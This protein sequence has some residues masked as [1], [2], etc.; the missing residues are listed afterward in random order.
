MND[1]VLAVFFALNNEGDGDVDVG[2]RAWGKVLVWDTLVHSTP[3]ICRHALIQNG[4]LMPHTLVP[5][6]S[7]PA[8]GAVVSLSLQIYSI[9][10]L[11]GPF[12][13]RYRRM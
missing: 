5:A 13:I 9:A 8:D 10:A 3:V 12:V 2:S 6:G 7:A 1:A 11:I 4:L